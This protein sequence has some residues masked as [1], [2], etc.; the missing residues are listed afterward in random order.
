MG[1]SYNN[2][3]G[4]NWKRPGLLKQTLV[5]AQD[6]LDMTREWTKEGLEPTLWC[7]ECGPHNGGGVKNVTDR[8]MSSFWYVD[9]LGGLARLGLKQHGR[10]ALVGSHYGLVRDFS[11]EPN[12]D[13]FALLAWK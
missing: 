6:M 8:V 7:G 2:D 4:N 3:G 12:P 11:Y 13:Y 10:Q 5:Q 1:H 9:A